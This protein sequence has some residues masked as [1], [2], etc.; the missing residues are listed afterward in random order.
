MWKMDVFVGF[1]PDLSFSLQEN[2]SALQEK[3][4]ALQSQLNTLKD[5]QLA[6]DNEKEERKKEIAQ[7]SD[8]LKSSQD[9]YT[10]LAGTLQSVRVSGS[11]AA[12][13]GPGDRPKPRWCS[14]PDQTPPERGR[15]EGNS[16]YSK[17]VA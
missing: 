17:C 1:S 12:R 2:Q 8:N 3:H 7:L 4:A 15:A 13:R 14:A 6:A 9:Q 5:E 10:Q 16:S 11:G